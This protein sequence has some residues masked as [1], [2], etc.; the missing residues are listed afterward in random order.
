MKTL[1]RETGYLEQVGL[2]DAD[3]ARATGAAKSTARAW[4]SETSAPTGE[5]AERL[6]ELAAMVERLERVMQRDYVPVWLRKPIPAL[7]EHK[8]LDL[9]GQGEYRQVAKVISG[10]ED[11]PAA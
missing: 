4:L 8:P 1:L 11:T 5:R 6:I 9:I 7:D 3:L 2:S 10:L